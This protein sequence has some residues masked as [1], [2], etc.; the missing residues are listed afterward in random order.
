MLYSLAFIPIFSC[1]LGGPKVSEGEVSVTA[2]LVF[3]HGGAR[4]T[5]PIQTVISLG[6]LEGDVARGHR[7]DSRTQ[8]RRQPIALPLVNICRGTAGFS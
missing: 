7:A 2:A 1:F 3:S 4:G 5:A 6:G 8:G